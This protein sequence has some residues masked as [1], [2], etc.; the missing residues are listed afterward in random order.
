[1]F[2][3]HILF[4]TKQYKKH[5]V[6]DW[7]GEN[8]NGSQLNGFRWRGGRR[9]DTIGIWMW[10]EI[11]THDFSNGDKIAIIL[12]DTQG[13]FD[14]QSTRRDC[15]TTFALSMLLSSVQCYNVM[16]NV[17]EDDLENLEMFAEYGRLAFEQTNEKPFQKLLFIIRDWPNEFEIDY[18][19]N[20]QQVIDEYLSENDSQLS[21]HNQLRNRIKSSFGE[22]KAFLMPHPGMT[23]AQGRNFTGQLQQIDSEFIKYVKELVPAIFAP[24]NLVIKK[25][26]N[27]RVRAG[28]LVQYLQAYATL[29]NGNSL[30]EPKTVLM[31]CSI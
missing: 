27:E 21:E 16:Q 28:D 31:V 17:Q 9:P 7:L 4:F 11:F 12:M 1:M 18:G 23:V 19:W 29:F 3:L 6:S 24:E 25:I 13:I 20:G 15:T 30:P 22:I 5:D 26:N 10:S 14:H 2:S 8:E